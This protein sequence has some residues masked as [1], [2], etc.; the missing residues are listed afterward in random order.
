MKFCLFLKVKIVYECDFGE[1]DVMIIKNWVIFCGDDIF[2]VVKMEFVNGVYFFVILNVMLLFGWISIEIGWLWKKGNIFCI[3]NLDC[4]FDCFI[5]WMIVGVFGMWWVK[6]CKI[7]IVISVFRGSDMCRMD[8]LIFFNFVWFEFKNVFK[9]IFEKLLVVGM[10]D[11]MWWGGFF[12]LN[13][14]F[15]YLDWFIVSENG[16][17]FLLY[18]FIYMVICISG[19]KMDVGNDDW[20]VEGFVEFYFFEFIYCV[21]G[22]IDKCW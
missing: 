4:K 6:V 17:S 9:E 1:F 5:G 7:F 16:I 11:F 2:L 20:I 13:L 22:M 15:L 14:F 12:G 3:Y 18:E 19:I 21:G 8:V 10:D